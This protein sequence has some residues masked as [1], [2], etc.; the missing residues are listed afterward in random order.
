M[1][2]RHTPEELKAIDKFGMPTLAN[3]LGTF[4]LIPPNTGFC[5]P[6]MCCHFPELGTMV[7]YAVTT[8]VAADQPASA[9]RPPILESDYLRYV[10]SQP[11]P[12][13]VVT[14]DIDWPPVGAPWGEWNANVHKALG[15]V[16]MVT[17]GG[18]RDLEEARR[19]GFH[20]FSTHILVSHG[21][22]WYSSRGKA[23]RHLWRPTGGRPTRG[24]VYPARSA[25]AGPGAGGLGDRRAGTENLCLLPV[26][27][28]QH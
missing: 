16:G 19:L 13:I 8:R 24:A 1:Q 21:L 9:V 6:Q 22:W 18:A 11:G 10:A 2:T 7:G 3:A 14:Q 28:L 20:F 25:L 17:Q 5:G 23:G 26:T 27:R 4:G 12:K 15:C